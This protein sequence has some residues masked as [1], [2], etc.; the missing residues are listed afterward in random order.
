MKS[1]G[2]IAPINTYVLQ[3]LL[4]NSQL[5]KDIKTE[6]KSCFL[7]KWAGELGELVRNINYI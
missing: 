2:V 4:S 3:S 7:G 1:K 6:E 5:T